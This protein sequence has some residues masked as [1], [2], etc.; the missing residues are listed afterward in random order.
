MKRFFGEGLQGGLTIGNAGAGEAEFAEDMAGDLLV[1]GIILGDE[2]M[3]IGGGLIGEWLFCLWLGLG[4][5][6]GGRLGGDGM[7]DLVK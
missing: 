4:V 2:D 1:G 5:G 7:E 3:E 6:L